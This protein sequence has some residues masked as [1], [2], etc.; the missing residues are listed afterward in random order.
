M[1]LEFN[2]GAAANQLEHVTRATIFRGE[3]KLR[4]R[5]NQLIMKKFT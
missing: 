2:V 5:S 4:L 3:Q 1:I